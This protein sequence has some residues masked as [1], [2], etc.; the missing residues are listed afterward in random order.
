[1]LLRN[2][3]VDAGDDRRS[4]ELDLVK[5]PGCDMRQPW[6]MQPS[7]PRIIG[8]DAADEIVQELYNF[9]SDSQSDR[10]PQIYHFGSV[11]QSILCLHVAATHVIIAV[12]VHCYL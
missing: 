2:S 1:M 7:S 4:S 3:G 11:Y 12:I 8:E 9:Q 6:F 10:D 5:F